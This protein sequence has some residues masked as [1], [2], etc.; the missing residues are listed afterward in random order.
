MTSE[1]EKVETAVSY[2]KKKT[3]IKPTIGIVLGSGLGDLAYELS[4]H[5]RI[6]YEDI[7]HFPLSTV[8]GHVGQLVFG[9]LEGKN[10]VLMQ[11]RFHYYEGYSMKEVTF[12]V[13]VMQQLGIE[14]F[15]V[16]NACGALHSTLSP[17][18]LLV[19]QDHLNLTGTNPLIGKN[20]ERFG[21]RFPDM[22]DAYDKQLQHLAHRA[23]ET[24][25]FSLKQG[26]YAGISGPNYMTRSELI[27]VRQLGADVV[28]MSTVPEVIVDRHGG[29][30]VLGLSCITDMAIGETMEGISH[31]EV[32]EVARQTKPR[33]MSLMKEII[34]Q[35]P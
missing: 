30:P 11:G 10:V 7:P 28:G 29:L 8:E 25:G 12:P 9:Q 1:W 27:M 35:H 15:V 2:I 19:I 18:D 31:E 5:T 17:G 13:R 24:L 26:I 14:T 34:K 33:F 3:E 23:A 32:M 4:D 16:T 20:D 22:S 21:P 6:P